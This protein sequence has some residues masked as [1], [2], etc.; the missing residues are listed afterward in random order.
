MRKR[1]NKK[2]E[3]EETQKINCHGNIKLTE[4]QGWQMSVTATG[5][6]MELGI[7]F[8]EFWPPKRNRNSR[9]CSVHSLCILEPGSLQL[10]TFVINHF[11]NI[12]SIYCDCYRLIG[13]TSRG[14]WVGNPN[15]PDFERIIISPA[16]S[17]LTSLDDMHATWKYRFCGCLLASSHRTFM[18]WCCMYS[19]R[20]LMMDGE[21]VWN[22]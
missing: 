1:D 17:F 18:V 7:S 14:W 9:N 5:V 19:L 6:A 15:S 16:L 21:T 12:A 10:S 2:L 3:A 13:T 11:N 20:L 22:M 4:F 8:A